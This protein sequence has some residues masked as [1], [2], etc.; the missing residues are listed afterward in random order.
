M[1]PESYQIPA[2]AALVLLLASFI[3]IPAILMDDRLKGQDPSGAMSSET[4]PTSCALPPALDID[5]C[6]A[7]TTAGP[8]PFDKMENRTLETATFALG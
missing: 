3:I 5:E 4:D 7:R 6:A 8:L 2:F 1:I